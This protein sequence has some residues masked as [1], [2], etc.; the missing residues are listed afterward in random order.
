[1]P[2]VLHIQLV[3]ECIPVGSIQSVAVAGSPAMHTATTHAPTAVHTPP[4][5]VCPCNACPLPCM[6]PFTT[7][8]PLT[9]HTLLH[10]TCPPL[11]YMPPPLCHACPPS[12]H[13]PP[14]PCGQTDACEDNTFAQLLLRT[15]KMAIANAKIQ[16]INV[17]GFSCSFLIC[18]IGS[19]SYPKLVGNSI[20]K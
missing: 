4:N 13:M 10:H 20:Q 16:R 11:P 18:S 15:V 5:H 7:H 12:P 9:M 8:A 19:L 2:D 17:T 6:S 1:M 14:L 3:Q